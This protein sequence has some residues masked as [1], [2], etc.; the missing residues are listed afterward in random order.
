MNF[1][2]IYT[3]LFNNLSIGT[4]TSNEGI[5]IKYEKESD[6]NKLALSLQGKNTGWCTAG[7]EVAK[8][9]LELGDF[10]IYYTKDENNEYKNPRIAI[11]MEDNKI[12]IDN[13]NK[14]KIKLKNIE[15]HKN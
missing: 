13:K 3:K 2:K 12:I 9:Q 4:C 8:T 5:W 6:P 10:Y 15:I 14:I 11:R 1:R 7:V